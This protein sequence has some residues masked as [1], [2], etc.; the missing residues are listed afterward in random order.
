MAEWQ[1]SDMYFWMLII[2]CRLLLGMISGTRCSRHLL[3]VNEDGTG[4]LSE[5]HHAQHSC[6]LRHKG[7]TLYYLSRTGDHG[8]VKKAYHLEWENHQRLC[9]AVIGFTLGFLTQLRTGVSVWGQLNAFPF[10]YLWA[11]GLVIIGSLLN[12]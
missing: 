6:A 11:Y 12:Q 2:D 1:V 9:C 3:A 10:A 7:W 5:T 4:Q 8:V